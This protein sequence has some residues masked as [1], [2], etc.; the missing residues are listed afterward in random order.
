MY[1]SYLLVNARSKKGSGIQSQA[2]HLFVAWGNPSSLIPLLSGTVRSCHV[3][4][5]AGI[6]KTPAL[7]PAAGDAKQ[8]LPVN[9]LARWISFKSKQAH[10]LRKRNIN[11]I[12]PRATKSHRR[13][14]T[15]NDVPTHLWQMP[16][17]R[18]TT[19]APHSKVWPCPASL[20]W[21]PSE[22]NLERTHS[23]CQRP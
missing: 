6:L 2:R 17:L 22:S 16:T 5:S 7:S 23:Y 11:Q 14:K 8:Y 19:S 4:N 3:P 20:Y 1:A 9:N 18:K 21:N 12:T 10:F 13:A 15:M